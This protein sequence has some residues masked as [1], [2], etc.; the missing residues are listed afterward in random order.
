MLRIV[1]DG[2][3]AVI[4]ET[5]SPPDDKSLRDLQTAGY[6]SDGSISITTPGKVEQI[7]GP[8]LTKGWFSN[9]YSGKFKFLTEKRVVLRVTF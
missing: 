5:T 1:P 2:A 3:K 6:K 7:S 4:V 8:P 9:T